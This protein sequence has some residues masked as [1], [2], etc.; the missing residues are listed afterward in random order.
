MN[1]RANNF[2]QQLFNSDFSQLMEY[3]R[4]SHN[5]PSGW[6]KDSIGGAGGRNHWFI[7]YDIAY[8]KVFAGVPLVF[9]LATF[10]SGKAPIGRAALSQTVG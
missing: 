1:V 2:G 5:S 7:N 10:A 4:F 3:G 9:I 6:T 8:P